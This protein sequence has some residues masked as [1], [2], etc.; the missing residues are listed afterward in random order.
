MFISEAFSKRP[1]DKRFYG[2]G[3]SYIFTLSPQMEVWPWAKMDREFMKA[4]RDKYG[5]GQAVKYLTVEANSYFIKTTETGINVGAGAFA[6][7]SDFRNG[8]TGKSDTFNSPPLISGF[9]TFEC[10]SVEVYA[11]SK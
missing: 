8:V 7:D 4:D 10:A 9:G 6:F 3:E 2:T 5:T 1:K 11:V